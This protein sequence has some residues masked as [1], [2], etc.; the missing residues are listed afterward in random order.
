MVSL[1]SF[2][3][4]S[5]VAVVKFALVLV[6]IPLA[7]TFG[8][9]KRW[10]IAF[11]DDMEVFRREELF[12]P[13]S[14]VI[15][16]DISSRGAG[17]TVGTDT[18]EVCFKGSTE[19]DEKYVLMDSCI[20]NST[21]VA[22]GRM[23]MVD[24]PN[25]RHKLL[26]ALFLD[27][28]QVSN[29]AE[30]SFVVGLTASPENGV[31]ENNRQCE[32]PAAR[33]RTS[34]GVI[35]KYLGGGSGL[36]YGNHRNAHYVRRLTVEGGVTGETIFVHETGDVRLVAERSR[37]GL[38]EQQRVLLEGALAGG[39]GSF[40]TVEVGSSDDHK[41]SFVLLDG[42]GGRDLQSL[43][44]RWYAA[45]SM[46]LIVVSNY[47]SSVA[48]RNEFLHRTN[49]MVTKDDE[50]VVVKD[51]GGELNSRLAI[52]VVSITHP[53]LPYD[54]R[55]WTPVVMERIQR[56]ATKCEAEVLVFKEI[57]DAGCDAANFR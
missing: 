55:P 36:A 45:P 50:L 14:I 49:V 9:E 38:L 26:A 15:K 32:A 22:D 48:L 57:H 20:K 29:S 30:F 41:P 3:A 35:L 24:I 43:V 42:G 7:W 53:G 16:V 28:T 8:E 23:N 47:S 19:N 52:I 18:L 54:S 4:I 44:S 12:W 10:T 6:I 27:G 13:G 31:E 46:R 51:N 39:C 21:R 17:E 5:V 40:N 1:S 2:R 56:Y 37:G 34:T 25:G 11:S 33:E